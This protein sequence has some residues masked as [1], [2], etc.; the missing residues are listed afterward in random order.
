MINIFRPSPTVYFFVKD[1]FTK[2]PAAKF[3]VLRYDWI[4]L[5]QTDWKQTLCSKK[6]DIN[7]SMN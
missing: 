6:N 1:F 7:F 5:D 3:N 4:K 2:L